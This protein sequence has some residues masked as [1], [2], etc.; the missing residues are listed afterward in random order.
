MKTYCKNCDVDLVGTKYQKGTWSNK[1]GK[2]P[3]CNEPLVSPPNK[4]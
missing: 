3:V 1:T 4:K 2:C